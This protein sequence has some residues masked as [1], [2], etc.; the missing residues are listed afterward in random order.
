MNTR[1]GSLIH[2]YSMF[3]TPAEHSSG[4]TLYQS[5]S[6]VKPPMFTSCHSISQRRSSSYG[7][8]ASTRS[9]RD[10]QSASISMKGSRRSSVCV[11]SQS[12]QK[13]SEKSERSSSIEGIPRNRRLSISTHGNLEMLEREDVPERKLSV[14]NLSEHFSS[15]LSLSSKGVRVRN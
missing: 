15:F 8:G 7:I 14:A 4:S 10:A 12:L 2:S 5:N 13:I 1:R 11:P 9:S 6:A 3:Q